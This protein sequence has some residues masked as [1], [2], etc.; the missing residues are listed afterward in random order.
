MKR[1]AFALAF[2]VAFALAG[3]GTT[4]TQAPP[5][6]AS[7][8]P[9]PFNGAAA[10]PEKK[11]APKGADGERKPAK[12]DSDGKG[13]SKVVVA[14]VSEQRQ[15]AAMLRSIEA[16]VR[17]GESGTLRREFTDRLASHPDD[18]FARMYLAWV[19]A[20]S[21]EAANQ[22]GALAKMNPD[23]PWLRTALA[24]TYL[25][26][27]GFLEVAGQEIE[28]VLEAS[29]GFAPALA[30]KGEVARR[31]GRQED[32]V[33]LFRQALAGDEKNF[34]A[35]LGLSYALEAMGDLTA[36]HEAL[37]AA[38]AVDD[39]DPALLRKQADI[40]LKEGNK[41]GAIPV[42]EKLMAIFPGDAA[43]RRQIGSLKMELGDL[44]EAAKDFETLMAG[45][46]SAA[47]A[48]DL[49]DIYSRLGRRED[50][51][52][53]LES[54]VQFE[55]G[56]TAANYR[57]L[58]ELRKQD[59][60]TEGATNAL[61]QAVKASPEDMELR[62]MLALALEDRGLVLETIEAYRKAVS[63]GADDMAARL[64]KMEGAVGLQAKPMSGNVNRIYNLTQI[65]LRNAL[66][67]RQKTQPWLGGAMGA[68]IAIGE[69]GSVT[70][71]EIRNDEVKDP[72]MTALLYFS[73]LDARL[74]GERPRSVSFEFVLEAKKDAKAR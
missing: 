55:E 66:A 71:V 41:S 69:D 28:R 29:P 20:P 21:E 47:V 1:N 10:Q 64:R 38:I 73:L 26:W 15:V 13:T 54:W 63:M 30:L 18:L 57:R 59:G 27:N 56:A 4:T 23:E 33:V 72:S 17:K 11:D 43:M 61:S 2:A 9:R 62:R 36:A 65:R 45:T 58:Y 40:L 50:E 19:D 46:P 60:D 68:R 53:S 37:D 22:L 32:A 3:C 25:N 31:E 42:M 24:K 70:Q 48:A 44:A 74:P 49:S 35:L 51:Q 34:D 14:S 7:E 39:G 12:K 52:R 6:A 8:G 16:R 5:P 67:K